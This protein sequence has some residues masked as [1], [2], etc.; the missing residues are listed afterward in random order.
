MEACQQVIMESAE[1]GFPIVLLPG[2]STIREWRHPSTHEV[3][4]RLE[5]RKSTQHGDDDE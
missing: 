3:H 1:L 4:W 2:F 5:R